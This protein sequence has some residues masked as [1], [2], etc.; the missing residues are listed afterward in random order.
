MKC[1][2]VEVS[3]AIF[4]FF[5]LKNF[6]QPILPS[7]YGLD[8]HMGEV[9]SLLYDWMVYREPPD[10]LPPTLLAAFSPTRARI[11]KTVR[12]SEMR[13]IC[14]LCCIWAATGISR[15][16]DWRAVRHGFPFPYRVDWK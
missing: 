1:P 6:P 11:M 8:A 9:L 13:V 4:L 15:D 5:I 3:W 14:C 2:P 7:G 10:P 16:C 12:G